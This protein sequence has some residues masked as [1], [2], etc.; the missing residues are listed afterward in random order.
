M[1]VAELQTSYEFSWDSFH[2][3]VNTPTKLPSMPL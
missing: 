2:Y 3:L 1:K